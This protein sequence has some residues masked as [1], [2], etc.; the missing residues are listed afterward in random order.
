MGFMFT[1]LTP[2]S[3]PAVQPSAEGS[4]LFPEPS[5]AEVRAGE[6]GLLLLSV[7]A[8]LGAGAQ[9]APG[10]SA[11]GLLTGF[12][13]SRQLGWGGL[14]QL[15]GRGRCSWGSLRMGVLLR[16]QSASEP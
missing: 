15:G 1:Q 3:S 8:G 10:E 13:N 6:P 9:A 2:S 5:A 11:L 16:L 7:R 4:G 12:W 14:E